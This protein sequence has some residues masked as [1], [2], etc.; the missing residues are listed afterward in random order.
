MPRNHTSLG[1]LYLFTPIMAEDTIA[2]TL[3]ENML[4]VY[5]AGPPADETLIRQWLHEIVQNESLK[6]R[7]QR[8]KNDRDDPGDLYERALQRAV[9]EW[10]Q[11][12]AENSNNGP[13]QVDGDKVQK[14]SFSLFSQL[15]GGFSLEP[16]IAI[17]DL[18]AATTPQEK[19]SMLQKVTHLDDIL[20]DWKEIAPV[21][22]E[23]LHTSTAESCALHRK[24]FEQGRASR[25]HLPIRYDLCQNILSSISYLVADQWKDS[26][27]LLQ[28]E[29][30]SQI[31]ESIFALWHL[32]WEMWMDLLQEPITH[33]EQSGSLATIGSQVLILMRD[34]EYDQPC[35]IYPSHFLALVDPLSTWFQA[36]TAR[37]I[38]SELVSLL[39]SS[40]LLPDLWHRATMTTEALFM[41]DCKSTSQ[42][43]KVA[44]KHQS[45]AMLKSILLCTRN[46]WFPSTLLWGPGQTVT[47]PSNPHSTSSLATAFNAA[48]SR[49]T[50]K[51]KDTPSSEDTGISANQL[52]CLFQ[53]FFDVGIHSSSA[54]SGEQIGIVCAAAIEVLL[55]GAKCQEDEK[56]IFAQMHKACQERASVL[57]KK[58]FDLLLARLLEGLKD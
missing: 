44:A 27:K 41:E 14:K 57:E 51:K 46:F 40:A 8:S 35:T 50:D 33:D 32:W 37:L 47:I 24:W 28:E 30:F 9:E 13:P 2:T 25:E 42:L 55:F 10:K 5:T 38:P 18:L 4:L 12:A 7:I 3:V 36:W 31:Q 26:G 43:L 15:G 29:S 16:R 21:L 56:E 49:V 6:R 45:L 53:V 34:V 23:T 48:T 19:L 52:S 17:E 58:A 54:K 22:Q 1:F 20:F 11:K 39:R